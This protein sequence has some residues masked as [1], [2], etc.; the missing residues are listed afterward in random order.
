MLHLAPLNFF[1]IIKQST[2]KIIILIFSFQE[3]TPDVRNFSLGEAT[4]HVCR[5]ETHSDRM[6]ESFTT[7]DPSKENSFAVQQ[8]VLDALLGNGHFRLNDACLIAEQSAELSRSRS[9]SP[10]PQS[11]S[12]CHLLPGDAE[13]DGGSGRTSGSRTPVGNDEHR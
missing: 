7:C 12:G 5:N 1:K 8:K 2:V 10:Y 3:A 4:E 9:G 13:S 11:P 6:L